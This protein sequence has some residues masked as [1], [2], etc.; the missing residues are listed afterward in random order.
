VKVEGKTIETIKVSEWR[1]GVWEALG[2]A[3]FLEL[4]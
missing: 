4:F 3:V 2:E 1:F